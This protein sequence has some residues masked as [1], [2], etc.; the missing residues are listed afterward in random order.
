M[1]T[2]TDILL[3]SCEAKIAASVLPA[4]GHT[5]WDVTPGSLPLTCKIPHIINH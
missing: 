3:L 4:V 5:Q 2:I 1:S